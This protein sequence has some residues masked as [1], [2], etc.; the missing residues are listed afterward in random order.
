M[1]YRSRYCPGTELTTGECQEKPSRHKSTWTYLVMNRTQHT[2]ALR[3]H[4]DRRN[5]VTATTRTTGPCSRTEGMA[6]LQTGR[7]ADDLR[8]RDGTG[9]LP[10]VGSF[11]SSKSHPSRSNERYEGIMMRTY[12]SRH[13]DIHKIIP[14][15]Q[16]LLDGTSEKLSASSNTWP[17]SHLLSIKKR[18]SSPSPTNLLYVQHITIEIKILCKI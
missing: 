10:A 2:A 17:S 18:L 8:G 14:L 6:R 11:F 4:L 16:T 13:R 15:L 3:L 5:I 1:S 9:R 7:L 12:L